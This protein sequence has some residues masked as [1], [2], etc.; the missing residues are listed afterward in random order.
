MK[1]LNIIGQIIIAH[2]RRLLTAALEGKLPE[3]ITALLATIASAGLSILSIKKL[4]R[5]VKISENKMATEVT[6]DEKKSVKKAVKAMINR[7]QD[8]DQ[9]L[10]YNGYTEDEVSSDPGV[11]RALENYRREYCPQYYQDTTQTGKKKK[12][13]KNK[14]SDAP[15]SDLNEKH[16]VVTDNE[17]GDWIFYHQITQNFT[18][19]MCK[20]LYEK[21]LDMGFIH[22]PWNANPHKR[23]IERIYGK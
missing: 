9:D 5:K 14:V 18:E 11:A 6:K 4:F 21:L 13:G 20:K 8:V 22:G 1:I 12:G 3:V 15:I 19:A 2:G 17:T 7:D 16:F 23:E 10:R